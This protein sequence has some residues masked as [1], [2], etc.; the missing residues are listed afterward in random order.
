MN[1]AEQILE[2]QRVFEATGG[3]TSEDPNP[4]AELDVDIFTEAQ[5]ANIGSSAYRAIGVEGLKTPALTKFR[6]VTGAHSAAAAR[7]T[8]I[9][10][11]REEPLFRAGVIGPL[12]WTLAGTTKT[13]PD[14]RILGPHIDDYFTVPALCYFGVIGQ[15]MF[16]Y[17]GNYTL[18]LGRLREEGHLIGEEIFR[19]WQERDS[20][21]GF[22][23]EARDQLSSIYATQIDSQ[24]IKPVEAPCGLIMATDDHFLHSEGDH[25]QAV[26][27]YRGLVRRIAPLFS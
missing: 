6:R 13:V 15:P 2:R 9:R 12:H 5:A 21:K 27:E 1:L 25:S 7:G 24:G 16:H 18:D 3:F 22:A 17:P 14:T 8:D 20:Y 11:Y 26:G 4:V 19:L 23:Y 10:V